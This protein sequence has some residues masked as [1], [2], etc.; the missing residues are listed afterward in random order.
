MGVGRRPWCWRG[1]WRERARE[2]ARLLDAGDGVGGAEPLLACERDALRHLVLELA[3]QRL[4]LG[5]KGRGYKVSGGAAWQTVGW[6][7]SGASDQEPQLEVKQLFR[8]GCRVV[9]G[10]GMRGCLCT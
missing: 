7:C 5:G 9:S 3:H 2:G 10:D 6:R 1:C 4:R 8:R